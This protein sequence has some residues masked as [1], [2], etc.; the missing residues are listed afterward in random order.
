MSKRNKIRFLFELFLI[1]RKNKPIL[2]QSD[3]PLQV[4]LCYK[5]LSQVYLY[6]CF[7]LNWGLY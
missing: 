3:A 5:Y 6:T 4:S 7:F 1:K 2:K